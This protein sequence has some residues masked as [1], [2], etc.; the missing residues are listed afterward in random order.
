M[1]GARVEVV[2][3]FAGQVP[4]ALYSLEFWPCSCFCLYIYTYPFFD[5]FVCGWCCFVCPA[6]QGF[7]LVVCHAVLALSWWSVLGYVFGQ[8]GFRGFFVVAI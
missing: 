8:H 5:V 4:F 6:L 7:G 3:L 2:L 1:R